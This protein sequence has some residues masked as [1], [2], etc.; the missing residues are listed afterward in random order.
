MKNRYTAQIL[1]S[2]VRSAG[3]RHLAQLCFLAA[4][5]SVVCPGANPTVLN[6]DNLSDGS[7]LTGQYFGVIF[8]NT[9]ILSTGISLNEFEFPPHSGTKVASD[10]GGPIS[11]SFVA[12][13][14]SF[15]AYFTH[16]VALTIKAFDASNAQVALA[17]SASSNNEVLSGS[18]GPNEFLQVA[19]AGGISR[20]EISGSPS[21]GSFVMDDVTAQITAKITPTLTWPTPPPITYGTALSSTQLNATSSTPGSFVY[22]PAAGTVLNA[23]SQT[24]SVTF[25]PTDTT[26]YTTANAMVTLQINKATPT[27]TFTGAPASA[28]YLST[29]TVAT[30]TN[31]SSTAVITASGSCSIAGAIITMTSPTGT[32]SLT[33][34]WAADNNYN[35]ATATQSTAAGKA[36]PTVTFTG[37]PASAAYRSTF[38]V[39][40]TTNSSS[41]AGITASGSCSISGT[42]VTMTSGTGT[43]G[44]TATWAADN[45][46]SSATASQSTAAT[47]INSTTTI[48][49]DTP[50]P[51]TVGQAVTVSFTV[52]GNGTPTGNVTVGDGA[53]DSCTATVAAGSCSLTFA[54]AGTKTLT[55]SYSGDG[56]FNSSSSAGVTQ[57]VNKANTTTTI[58]TH[59]PNPS[60][61]GQ[62]VTVKFTIVPVAPGSG[63]PTG[64]VTVADGAGDTCTATVASGGCSVTL[65]AS[66]TKTLTASY[67]GDTNFNSSTSAGVAHDVT[68]FSMSVDSTSQ[69]VKAGQRAKYTV[70]LTPLGAF[71]GTIAL[72]CAGTPPNATC[73]ASPTSVTLTRSRAG[74]SAF[75]VDTSK[76]T[77]TGTYTLTVTGAFG[78][79]VP[80][81]G[82]LT[83]SIQVRLTVN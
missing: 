58:T 36:T 44:L 73:S 68:D 48:T 80:A 83:R 17:T 64:N 35:S 10:D 75:T 46:Y 14:P 79:G 51:S 38:T 6:F 61:V 65:A 82:G 43:C 70:T 25:T 56:N 30:T 23:G 77:N 11:I 37:A 76:S 19:S 72:S 67:G 49:S 47:K 8:S 28:P 32:C 7:A 29:F 4:V 53:G 66:G 69:T 34:T 2:R 5:L 26:A 55:A 31:S 24:L 42:T 16:S 57:S 33:A 74:N 39:A 81:T 27:V 40:T 13:T 62:A 22:T 60:V 52:T 12:P 78:T 71:T 15:G 45:N 50:N 20:I 18:G 54:A 63:V 21:G 59:I 9:I 3:H 41:T 1:S